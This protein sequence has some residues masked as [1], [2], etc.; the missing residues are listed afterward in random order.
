MAFATSRASCRDGTATIYATTSTISGS[1]DQGA[2]PNKLVVITDKLS[3][4]TPPACE[5]FH[6][7]RSAGF[8]EVLRGVSWTPEADHDFF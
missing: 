5:S 8:G 7:V 1:G 2:D 3:A 4:T 6:T